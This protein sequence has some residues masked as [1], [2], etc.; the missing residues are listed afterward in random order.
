MRVGVMTTNGGS[1]PVEKWAAESA[2]QIVDVIVID[3]DS[4]VFE[5]VAAAKSK[6]QELL[7][8]T[9]VEDH[10]CVQAHEVAAITEHG[11]ARLS[12]DLEPEEDHLTQAVD[13][14][15][16]LADA[17]MFGPHFR[18]P[19]VRTFVRSTLRSHFTTVKQI[20][21]SWYADNKGI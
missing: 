8:E 19:E 12:Y 13:A 4:I 5:T 17:T 3:P 9:L 7:K 21:R 20:E 16:S 1:H 14:V 6:F 10:A 18:K 15:Q 2:A 11:H